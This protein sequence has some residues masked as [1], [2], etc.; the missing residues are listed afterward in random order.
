MTWVNSIMN[1]S[2]NNNNICLVYNYAQHYRK[3]IFQLLDKEL[4]CDFYFGDK[5]G[6]V[7]KLDYTYLSHFCGELQNKWIGHSFYYQKGIG[8]IL[9]KRYN[10]YIFLGEVRCLST[11][12]ALIFCKFSRRKIHLWTHGWYGKENYLERLL[13]KVFFRLADNVL[14]YGNYAHELMLKEGFAPEKLF[15]IHNS[16]SYS[17]QLKLRQNIATSCIYTDHFCNKNQNLI[18]I[19]RLTKVKRIDLQI[20]AMASLKEEQCNFNLT[21]IGDGEER[22]HLQNL[23]KIY[24]LENNVWF[25]GPCYDEKTNATLI[26]NADLCVSPGNVGLTAIHSLMFGCPVITHDNFA[27]QM[28]EFEAI[29]KGKTG[30]FFKQGDVNSLVLAIKKWFANSNLD[31]ESVRNAC[32]K[33]IDLSWTPIYQLDVIKKSL[34]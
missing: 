14:L 2:K 16:L 17:Q 21:L 22:S 25:Y 24:G 31:R 18:F 11:W 15:V 26:Y 32:Y 29:Q 8:Q 9:R 1:P 28:P 23:V 34:L 27:Y 20:K 10:H 19:G 12:L 33:E 4:E 13:K 5:M 6:D 3:E 7:K 30:D